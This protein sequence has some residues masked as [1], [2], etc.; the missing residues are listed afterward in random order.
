MR[1][2][3]EGNIEKDIVLLADKGKDASYDALVELVNMP[4]I[5]DEERKINVNTSKYKI[6]SN[7]IRRAA[8]IDR[9]E[10]DDLS[11]AIVDWRDNDDFPLM[12]GAESRYYRNLRFPYP[13]KNGNIEV[14]EELY[15]VKGMT[16]EIYK[17]IEPYIT[18]YGKGQVNINTASEMVLISLGI[19]SF[20]TSKIR[21]FRAGA[22]EKEGTFDDNIFTG[23]SSIVSQLSQIVPVDAGEVAILSNLM[24]SGALCTA[25]SAFRIT[26]IDQL[27]KTSY[28][29][30]VVCVY[31][32]NKMDSD[33]EAI[34]YWKESFQIAK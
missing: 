3:G 12:N 31:D 15:L 17:K 26:S 28:I 7:L 18:V 24:S 32:R 13:C 4:H 8:D 9:K 20:L 2:I 19:N 29:F 5:I 33:E 1:Y 6:I 30:E 11:A 21:S 25:S 22:D 23:P 16:P 10:A 14:P 34:M 27:R